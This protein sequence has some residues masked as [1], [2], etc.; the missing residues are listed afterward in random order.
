LSVEIQNSNKKFFL[1]A[2]YTF[3]LSK[4]KT[5]YINMEYFSCTLFWISY[6]YSV[7]N[8]G[9]LTTEMDLHQ[10]HGKSGLHWC[11][12][13]I[14]IYIYICNP[15]HHVAER[16]LGS[17]TIHN[18]SLNVKIVRLKKCF[19]LF[20]HCKPSLFI[21][22]DTKYDFDS[23]IY[24]YILSSANATFNNISVI[25]W[26]SVLLVEE[27]TDLRKSLTTFIT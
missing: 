8:H 6:R 14:Y 4:N 23:G 15:I 3:L 10:Q 5:A 20:L 16:A 2:I 7:H 11:I 24:I 1:V 18:S 13:Y 9:R 22:Q 17:L 12:I 21:S 27:T 19:C 26:R 25:P